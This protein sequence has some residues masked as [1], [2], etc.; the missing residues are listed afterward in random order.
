LVSIFIDLFFVMSELALVNSHQSAD[1][2]PHSLLLSR[3]RLRFALITL[4]SEGQAF[5][6]CHFCHERYIFNRDELETLLEEI[7]DA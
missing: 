7:S 1:M 5:I 6:D 4:G 3:E 2:A